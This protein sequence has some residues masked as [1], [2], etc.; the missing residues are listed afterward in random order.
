MSGRAGTVAGKNAV[1]EGDTF[2]RSVWGFNDPL[3][4]YAVGQ[5]VADWLDGKAIPQVI[6]L[7]AVEMTTAA[8]VDAWDV[9]LADPAAAFQLALAGE[10]PSTTFLGSI[11][12]ATKD[13]YLRNIIGGSDG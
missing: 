7:R 2:I 1:K 12:Y 4:G 10:E 3:H 9:G 11:S 8:E 6:Q 13:N 5:F